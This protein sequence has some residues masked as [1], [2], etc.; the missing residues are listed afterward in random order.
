MTFGIYLH[1]YFNCNFKKTLILTFILSLFF[2]LTQL[3]GLYF[4]Y[5][6][7]Y[8][9]FD[10]DDLLLNTI[11]GIIGY[12]IAYLFMKFLPS[13]D[14]IDK[15]AFENGKKVSIIKKITVFSLDLAL[16]LIAVLIIYL[17][18]KHTYILLPGIIYYIL[19]PFL[20]KGMT[21]GKKFLNLQVVSIDSKKLTLIRLIIR[22]IFLILTYIGLPTLLVFFFIIV[23]NNFNIATKVKVIVLIIVAIIIIVYYIYLLIKLLKK[24]YMLYELIS[25]TKTISTIDKK[26]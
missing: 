11:G 9:L 22:E 24:K 2:E 15:K 10:V 12:F 20:L 25:H 17:I 18:T 21:L 7:G 14:N 16:Y 5:E 3:T 1:Y 19:I 13:R 6:R 23:C 26:Q 8:R 4:I